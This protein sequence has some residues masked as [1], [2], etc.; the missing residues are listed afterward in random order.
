MGNSTNTGPTFNL[1]NKFYNLTLVIE[2]KT[3]RVIEQVD[4]QKSGPLNKV[5]NRE[6]LKMLCN[7]NI[8]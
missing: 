7:H 5:W 1:A 6:A 8:P 4:N 3:N 2:K